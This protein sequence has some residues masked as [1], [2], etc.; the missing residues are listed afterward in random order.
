MSR[1]CVFAGLL[2]LVPL[3]ASAQVVNLQGATALRF[4]AAPLTARTVAMAGTGIGMPDDATAALTNPAAL[5]LLVRGELVGGVYGEVIHLPIVTGGMLAKA[6]GG[7]L[8][9]T[10]LQVEDTRLKTFNPP[11]FFLAVAY[12]TTHVTVAGYAIY[13]AQQSATLTPLAESSSGAAFVNLVP[14]LG[15]G[16]TQRNFMHVGLAVSASPSPTLGVGGAIVMNSLQTGAWLPERSVEV[17]RPP[18]PPVLQ[19]RQVHA[20]TDMR[21]RVGFRVGVSWS[22]AP[23]LHVGAVYDR[24]SDHLSMTTLEALP[25]G[26]VV[27][28]LENARLHLPDVIGLGAGVRVTETLRVTGDVRRVRYSQLKPFFAGL[29]QTAPANETSL[30]L[31]DAT[32]L[33]L[34]TEYVVPVGSKAIALRAGT[35]RDSAHSLIYT[36]TDPVLREVFKERIGARMHGTVGVGFVAGSVEI[37]AG[38]DVADA[39]KTVIVSTTVRFK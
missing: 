35:W 17:P 20:A 28:R 4:D 16:G 18:L 33:R 24:G 6:A 26:N 1:V 27:S 39:Q 36:G 23:R 15:Q 34:G 3:V 38:G 29:L 12:P 25:G 19:Q 31:G 14:G 32:E 2:V 22:P 21:P 11:P 37:A 10:Q 7:T 8:V 9:P 5:R 13:R 30:D